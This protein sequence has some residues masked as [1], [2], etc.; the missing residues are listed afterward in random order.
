MNIMVI[1]YDGKSID[2]KQS[3]MQEIAEALNNN[4]GT[5]RVKF[6]TPETAD[7]IGNTVTH[8]NELNQ[9]AIDNAVVLISEYGEIEAS[10]LAEFSSLLTL[11]VVRDSKEIINA[12]FVINQLDSVT[13][14][15]KEV[16]QKY[17]FTNHHLMA[18]KAV[19]AKAVR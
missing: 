10:S 12:L 11:H 14:I 4:L 3:V 13:G 16:R 8:V 15:T 9:E 1:L 18:C 2:N 19:F 7:L 6:I 17:H 5:V